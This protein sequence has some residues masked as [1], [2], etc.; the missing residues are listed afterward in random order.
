MSNRSY[1][2]RVTNLALDLTWSLWAELGVS[3]WARRH[4]QTAI[5]LEPLI[6][7]SS[8]I[9]GSDARLLNESLDWCAANARFVS[10][11]R[12]RNL[13][14][15]FDQATIEAFG[16]FTA[17]IKKY[18]AVSWPGKGEPV[19]FSPTGRSSVPHLDRPA[20]VQL[21]LRATF[22]VS[23]RAELIKRM[24]P[25]PERPF[26]ISELAMFTAYGKDNIADALDMMALAGIVAR[27][28]M[29]TSGNVQVFTLAAAREIETL[30][31]E[32]PP[33]DGYP[34]WSARFRLLLKLVD[35]AVAGP[36][37][38][39]VRAAEIE[40]LVGDAQ[41]DLRWTGTFPRMRRGVEAVNK[42]FDEWSTG[43]LESWVQS[44]TAGTD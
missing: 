39:V 2:A 1:S 32:V 35:F 5:D 25:E 4:E 41:S 37:D 14:P 23:A 43:L 3:G 28:V 36:E 9:G 29:T 42:D 38:P 17:T 26:G 40:R 7:A 6:I 12:L 15:T 16:A 20:L 13:L 11:A 8:R 24:L 10:G 18:R 21:R 22:G 33:P 34:Y 27:N 44:P 30:L 19:K 31:G